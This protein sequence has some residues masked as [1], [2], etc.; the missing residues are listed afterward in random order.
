MTTFIVRNIH[1][2]REV[3]V[4][5]EDSD[6]AEHRWYLTGGKGSG[7]GKYLARHPRIPGGKP[8]TVYLHRIVALRMGLISQIRPEVMR[9]HWKN[10][11][12]HINGDKMDNR[13]ENLRLR[14]RPEQMSNTN[15]ALRS[16]NTSGY[17]GVSYAANRERYGKPWRATVTVNY[18]SKTIGWFATVEEAAEARR[19]WDELNVKG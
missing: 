11:V 15:D 9:G 17:R 7:A 4:S 19:K 13:R 1:G 10:S 5:E 14:T 8:I 12:D 3:Q 16:T 2:D 18:K 6:L